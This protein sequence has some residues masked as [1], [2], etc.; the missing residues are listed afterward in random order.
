MAMTPIAPR[1]SRTVTTGT[2][3]NS[4]TQRAPKVRPS[5]ALWDS[6]TA[7]EV[8]LG[9]SFSPKSERTAGSS[10]SAA[11]TAMATPMAAA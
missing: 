6:L 5:A 7:R 3:V 11:S 10:V 8:G 2:L 1:T 9:R 4:R